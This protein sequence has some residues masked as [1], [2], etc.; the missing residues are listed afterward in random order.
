MKAPAFADLT[1]IERSGL[2]MIERLIEEGRRADMVFVRHD[3]DLWTKKTGNKNV[4]ATPTFE[5]A[6]MFAA[7]VPAVQLFRQFDGS[8]VSVTKGKQRSAC[9]IALGAEVLQFHHQIWPD[10]PLPG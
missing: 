10:V 5:L 6:V 7:A 9:P 3:T 4:A 8:V 1:P 2:R